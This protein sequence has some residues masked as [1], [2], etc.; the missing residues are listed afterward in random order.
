M[1]PNSLENLLKQD[2]PQPDPAARVAARRAA[3]AEFAR[4]NPQTAN[5]KANDV[6]PKP[7][8][9][10]QGLLGLLRLSSQTRGSDTMPWYMRRGA[11]SGA[12]GV[13]IAVIGSVLVWTTLQHDPDVA[14]L[15]SPVAAPTAAAAPPAQETA[16][17]RGAAAPTEATSA[18]TQ[19][20]AVDTQ[21]RLDDANRNAGSDAGL[22]A[23]EGDKR[24][25]DL[26]NTQ[27]RQAEQSRPADA[28]SRAAQ[29]Q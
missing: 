27:A 29:L 26:M 3:L 22:R 1:K 6:T 17:P 19:D 21:Q 13:C 24:S 18:A 20:A 4:T 12:A 10:L 2:A 16:A 8:N 5:D 25:N 14:E 23:A 28:A 9:P 15:S 11:L 7:R